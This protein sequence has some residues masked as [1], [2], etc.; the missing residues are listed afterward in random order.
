[1]PLAF[2]RGIELTK[3]GVKY[4]QDGLDRLG[5][6]GPVKDD[7]MTVDV[8][9]EL[10]P[11]RIRRV[12]SYVPSKPLDVNRI[13]F[14]FGSFSEEARVDGTR[15]R[16]GRGDVYELD[17]EGLRQC[18]VETRTAADAYR[19]PHGAMKTR[20]SCSTESV[21]LDKPFTFSWTLKYR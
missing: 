14:E 16:F 9:Y 4:H 15:I 13:S 11:G 10:A 6:R 1:M 21:T 18:L 12:D 20:I 7:R 3:D 8:R 5:A 19:T 17:V 2:G